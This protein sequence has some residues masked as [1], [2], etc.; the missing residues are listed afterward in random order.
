[1]R[2]LGLTILFILVIIYV[3]VAIITHI[4]AL[5]TDFWLRSSSQYET[6]FL[7][8]GLWVA[9]FDHY[10]HAHESP[11]KEH[12]GCKRLSHPDYANIQDWLH[13]GW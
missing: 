2:G 6:N 12:D 5:S 7:N 1:M 11:Q 4:I 10:W 13:P 3:A 9:C 8:I